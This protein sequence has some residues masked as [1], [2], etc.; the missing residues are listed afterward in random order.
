MLHATVVLIAALYS[1]FSSN[2]SISRK[3]AVLAPN[4]RSK[5]ELSARNHEGCCDCVRVHDKSLVSSAPH[6]CPPLVVTPIPKTD[7]TTRT[8]PLVVT[9]NTMGQ[10]NSTHS[11]PSFPGSY[12]D[13]PPSSPSV[14]EQAH[15]G[16]IANQRGTGRTVEQMP[17]AP[18]G[19]EPIGQPPLTK[20]EIVPKSQTFF[21]NSQGAQIQNFQQVN[22]NRVTINAPLPDSKLEDGVWRF[23]CL[24][25]D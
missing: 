20:P 9:S 18:F 7:S 3:H 17:P 15:G 12:P 21:E 25:R 11:K 24:V 16:Q 13:S 22:D 2:I 23:Q 1:S 19:E 8:P 5:F 10:T 6:P 4:F 14:G